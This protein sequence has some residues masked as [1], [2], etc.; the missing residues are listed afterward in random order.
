[1]AGD[2]DVIEDRPGKCRKCG[3][4]LV[5]TRLDSVW[6][7]ATRPLLV[8]ADKPGKCP[9]DGTALGSRHRR[10]VVD[11]QGRSDRG[12]ARARHRAPTARR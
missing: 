8:V 4:T 9:V 2:E 3:M 10:G 7:C 12:Q 1:M 11:V 6:T 5:P